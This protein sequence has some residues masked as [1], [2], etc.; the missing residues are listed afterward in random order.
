LEKSNSLKLF[1]TAFVV[2]VLALAFIVSIADQTRT[3]TERTQTSQTFAGAGCFTPVNLTGTDFTTLH[4]QANGPT[5]ADCNFT[6]TNVPTGWKLE[7]A[8]DCLLV[9]VAVKN[10]TLTTLTEDTDYYF[11]TETGVVTLLNTSTNVRL[12]TNNATYVDY[13]YCSDDYLN[14]SW[15]RTIL[16]TNVGFLAIAVLAVVLWLV[17]VLLE[18]KKNEEY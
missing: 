14:T 2:V 3:V 13:T 1:I 15:G 16:N 17:Y 8:N 18:R 6:V 10:G 9:N 7:T 11:N 5:D 12:I 4:T